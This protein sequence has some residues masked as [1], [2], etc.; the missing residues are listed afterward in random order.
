MFRR[1]QGCLE[2]SVSHVP[3]FQ[4]PPAPTDLHQTPPFSSGRGDCGHVARYGI[5]SDSVL[6]SISDWQANR[7]VFHCR[8][9]LGRCCWPS[10]RRFP[11]D[12][13]T[14]WPRRVSVD[15]PLVWSLCNCARISTAVVVA[16]SSFAA[17][18]DASSKWSPEMAACNSAYSDW[19]RRRDPL[20]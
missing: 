4:V 9:S 6:P 3:R 20:S 12:G 1:R 8:S 11:E 16:R 18:R 7:S 14:R 17:W 13:W 2:S 5:L 19:Q 15:V 10:V